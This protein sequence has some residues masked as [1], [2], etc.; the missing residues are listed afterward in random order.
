MRIEREN[1]WVVVRLPEKVIYPSANT[2]AAHFQDLFETGETRIMVD[3]SK[4]AR[5]DSY[6]MGIIM[7]QWIKARELGGLFRMRYLRGEP[8]KCFKEARIFE[9]LTGKPLV[10]TTAKQV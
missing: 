6:G 2:V 4:M 5:V 10:S 1:D 9:L 8:E 7:K 3:A